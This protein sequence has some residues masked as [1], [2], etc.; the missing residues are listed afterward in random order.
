MSSIRTAIS[1]LKTPEKM[2]MPMADKG[3]F[4]WLPD[5]PYLKLVYQA[6]MG[7]KLDLDN[8]KTF[9]EKMQWLKLY[10]RNPFYHELVDK[11][12]VKQFVTKRIGP[13]NVIPS[14]GVW[15]KFEDIPFEQLPDQFVLKCTHDSCSV[16]ICLDKKKFDVTAAKKKLSH[17]LKKSTYWFGREWPYK[18]LT[19]RIIGEPYIKDSENGMGLADYKVHCFNGI[20]KIILVCKDRFS[21]GGVTEDFFDIHWNHLSV[22]RPDIDNAR[23]RIPVPEKLGEM[24][25]VSRTL[26]KNIPFV[27]VDFY[28]ANHQLYIGEMT[29]FPTS[30]LKSFLPAS[31]DYEMGS[32]IQLPK[33]YK[34]LYY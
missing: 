9:N 13:E 28:Y 6:E 31:F 23:I 18:G 15:R 4:N 26:S 10:D 7:K 24:L 33:P 21:E 8:P 12:E 19:P 32:W 11:Y 20:P 34:G 14:L 1:L 16:I 2:I 5:K 17:H 29:F 27:R 3:L 25:S 30:G 22:R